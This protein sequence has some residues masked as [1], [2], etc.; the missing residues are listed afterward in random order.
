MSDHLDLTSYGY[1]IKAELGR[2]REGGRITWKGIAI[3]NA[4]A[5]VIKQFCFA[6]AGSSWSG[7]RA[8]ERELSIL[9]KLRNPNIPQYIASIETKDG[10]CLIQ[11]YVEAIPSSIFRALQLEEV[12][13]IAEQVLDILI[14]LQ[15]QTPSILHRDIAP[16]NILLD[17]ALKVY[18]IDFGFARPAGDRL[19]SSSIFCGTPGFIAPEQIIQPTVASDLYSLGVTLVCL[20]TNRDIAEIRAVADADDPYQLNLSKLLPDLEPAWLNWLMKMTE[21]KISQRFADARTARAA[22]KA[23]EIPEDE[24]DLIVDR[25]DS[26]G[27]TRDRDLKPKIAGVAAIASTTSIATWGIYFAASRVEL[28]FSAAAVAVM[29]TVA[30]AVSQLGGAAIAN[31]DP[32]AKT[33]GILLAVFIPTILVA[34]SSLILGR[35]EAVMIAAGIAVVEVLLLSYFWRQLP[36]NQSG[37]TAG[38]WWFG[39]IATGIV[40]GLQLSL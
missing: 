33:Q 21:P 39:A 35:Q 38:S 31:S 2:N 25:N 16:A 4:K 11:E 37:W 6:Q 40:V 5:V 23:I 15:Q 17:E 18:L 29:A 13:H 26:L 14:Y 27:Q 24:L 12:R 7:Y 22:L 28:S 10:F 9:Q 19:P 1:Q 34:L 20:L 36:T 8:Y 30:I 3:N 32:Q